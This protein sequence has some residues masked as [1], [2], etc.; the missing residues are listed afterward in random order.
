MIP[1]VAVH[2]TPVA[3]LITTA[4]NWAVP[5]VAIAVDC[6]LIATVMGNGVGVVQPEAKTVRQTMA[7]QQ[8]DRGLIWGSPLLQSLSQHATEYAAI[9]I[10]NSMLPPWGGVVPRELIY[11]NM[12]TTTD[13]GGSGAATGGLETKRE[14][15]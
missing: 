9:E 1:V 12:P 8:R 11:G 15:E 13:K 10:L 6:G 4:L 3:S 7:S 2:V 14:S 5:P